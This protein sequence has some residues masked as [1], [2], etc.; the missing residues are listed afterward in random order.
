MIFGGQTGPVLGRVSMRL[1]QDIG[2][3]ITRILEM[4]CS[5]LTGAAVSHMPF[6]PWLTFSAR[7]SRFEKTAFPRLIPSGVTIGQEGST[8][9]EPEICGIEDPCIPATEKG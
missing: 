6:P 9:G 3:S 2:H 5:R 1:G 7:G 4:I 8:S